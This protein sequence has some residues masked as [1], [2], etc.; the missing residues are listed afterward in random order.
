MLGREAGAGCS[1]ATLEVADQR[2]THAPTTID[3]A[4]SLLMIARNLTPAKS[5][6]LEPRAANLRLLREALVRLS[7]VLPI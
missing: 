5:S 3:N 1:C 4:G 6:S 7:G 2:K